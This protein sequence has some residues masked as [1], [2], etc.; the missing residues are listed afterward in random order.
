MESGSA[1]FTVAFVPTGMN[2][3]VFISP[4]G[5]EIVP[6]LPIRPGICF[7]TEKENDIALN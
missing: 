4:W 3:G 5:V 7:P 2:A 1:D 6:L